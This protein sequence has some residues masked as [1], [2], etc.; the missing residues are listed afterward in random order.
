[1]R[2]QQSQVHSS[3]AHTALRVLCTAPY[4]L[5]LPVQHGPHRLLPSPLL[6]L[7]LSPPL[8]LLL[9][10]PAY[11]HEADP[12]S[13][14]R[15]VQLN[16]LGSAYAAR[17]LVRRM[18][19]RNTGHIVFVASAMAL[20]GTC[21][22]ARPRRL[23]VGG[24]AAVH[25]LAVWSAQVAHAAFPPACCAAAGMIGYCSY[26]PSKFAVRGLAESLRN[27]VGAAC[28]CFSGA[29]RTPTPTPWSTPLLLT[30]LCEL[31]DTPHLPEPLNPMC[32]VVPTP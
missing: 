11:F 26:A 9:L 12:R 18:L 13:L 5:V 8:L 1:M 30:H 3:H 14:E 22:A 7:T 32:S 19:A 21:S 29:V 24:P 10:L 28:G 23:Y 31:P 17:A 16:Y 25:S 6:L 2:A 27:E 15:A 20:M 4:C